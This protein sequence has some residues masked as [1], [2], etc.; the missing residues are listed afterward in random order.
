MKLF[1]HVDRKSE[2]DWVK[3]CM[4]WT[5]SEKGPRGRPKKKWIE[6]TKDH[7][8]RMGGRKEDAHDRVK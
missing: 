8:K 1:G 3:R 5:T 6:V 4:N 7:V 2:D